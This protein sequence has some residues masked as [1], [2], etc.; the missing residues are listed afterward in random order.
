MSGQASFVLF[1]LDPEKMGAFAP[2][3]TMN[4]LS[5]KPRALVTVVS[6]RMA[7]RDGSSNGGMTDLEEDEDSWERYGVWG[8]KPQR[9]LR[10]SSTHTLC[11]TMERM[12]L[13]GCEDV[14]SLNY[15]ATAA[16][17]CYGSPAQISVCPSLLPFLHHCRSLNSCERGP[18][19]SVLHQP[20]ANC[21]S[22]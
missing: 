16:R 15:L 5:L 6:I 19:D 2:P 13:V 9:G 18:L 12:W 22:R 1:V 21:V 11:S 4:L 10:E 14:G 7:K 3:S 20:C 8:G 17:K